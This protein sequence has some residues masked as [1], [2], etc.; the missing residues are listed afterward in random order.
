MKLKKKWLVIIPLFIAITV[1]LIVYFIFNGADEN[2]FTVQETNW[3][4]DNKNSVVDIAVI[5]GTMTI[6]IILM[7]LIWTYTTTFSPA[8]L[9]YRSCMWKPV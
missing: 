3:I 8:S 9:P 7:A 4:K 2:N 1:F 6:T 5:T